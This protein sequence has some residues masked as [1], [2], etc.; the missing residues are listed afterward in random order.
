MYVEAVLSL[1]KNNNNKKNS[2]DRFIELK[3][4]D[5]SSYFLVVVNG[6]CDVEKQ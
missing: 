4:K 5:F 6:G 1:N 3:T 2:G